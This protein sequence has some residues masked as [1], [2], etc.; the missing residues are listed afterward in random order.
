MKSL[1]LADNLSVF[2][3]RGLCRQ[4]VSVLHKSHGWVPKWGYDHVIKCN[5]QQQKYKPGSMC[6]N[7]N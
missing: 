3:G 4:F 6:G 5:V 2:G 7:V 1:V